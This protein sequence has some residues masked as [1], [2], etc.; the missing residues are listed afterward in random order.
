MSISATP[1]NLFA[2]LA[3]TKLAPE[4]SPPDG[5]H[6]LRTT[7]RRRASQVRLDARHSQIC[8]STVN[9]TYG[10]TDPTSQQDRGSLNGNLLPPTFP[11]DSTRE[12][13]FAGNARLLK[14][15]SLCFHPQKRCRG[16]PTVRTRSATNARRMA[17]LAAT[18]STR[19]PGMNQ[20]QRSFA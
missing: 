13:T 19:A 11:L 7:R 17:A 6:R 18:R 8:P 12:S 2:G 4:R 14:I 10:Q 9:G 16:L 20:K 3:R 15:C 5:T 1:S